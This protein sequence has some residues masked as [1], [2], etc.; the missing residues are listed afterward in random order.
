MSVGYFNYLGTCDLCL[1]KLPTLKDSN[2]LPDVFIVRESITN[3]NN[4]TNIRKNLKSFLGMPI[5]TRRSCLMKKPDEKNL[6]TLFLYARNAKFSH[7]S[8]TVSAFSQSVEFHST[9]NQYTSNFIPCIS[10]YIKLYS[11]Y[12]ANVSHYLKKTICKCATGSKIYNE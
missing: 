5:G 10:A 7:K 11:V 4:S 2:R 12:L 3:T 6:V 8:S 1:Q 9:Y